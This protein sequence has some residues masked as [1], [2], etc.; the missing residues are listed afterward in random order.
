MSDFSQQIKNSVGGDE[1]YSPQ[2]V[3][4]MILPYIPK[5]KT[6]WCPFDKAESNFVQTFIGGGTK[7]RMGI[8]KQVKTSLIIRNPKVILW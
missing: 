6:I 7:Y 3:V 8:L 5:D 4:D 1:Y 2:N